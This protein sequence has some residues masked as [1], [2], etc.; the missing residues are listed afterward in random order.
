MRLALRPARPVRSQ[1]PLVASAKIAA[2]WIGIDRVSSIAA[3]RH[4]RRVERGELADELAGVRDRQVDASRSVRA[5]AG[6]QL[7]LTSLLRRHEAAEL[8]TARPG[9]A[10]HTDVDRPGP[11]TP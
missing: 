10:F 9:A 6:G 4:V 2:V 3:T 7:A 1:R 11:P 5:N 8:E